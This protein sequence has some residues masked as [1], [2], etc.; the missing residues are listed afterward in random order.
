MN[1]IPTVSCLVATTKWDEAKK[2][3]LHEQLEKQT[4]IIPLHPILM[5]VKPYYQ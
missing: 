2:K 1:H 4:P 5:V 3:K